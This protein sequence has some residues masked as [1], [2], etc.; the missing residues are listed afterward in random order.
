MVFTPE[1]FTDKTPISL[2]KY[3]PVKNLIEKNHSV[4][5]LGF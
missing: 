5:F 4:N 3:D 1:E 2:D